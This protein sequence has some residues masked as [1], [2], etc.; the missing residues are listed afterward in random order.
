MT[1]PAGLKPT[2]I[3]EAARLIADLRLRRNGREGRIAGLPEHCRPR[4]LDD[5]YTIQER[6]RPLIAAGRLWT[7]RRLQ[8]RGDRAR[9]CR[10]GS[11]STIPVRARCS[12]IASTRAVPRS[13]G[14]LWR[15]LGVECEIGVRIGRDV[16]AR[17]GGHDRDSILPA[18]AA[19]FVSHR[20]RRA[21]FHGRP[22]RRR[23]DACRRRLLFS[24]RRC[25]DPSTHPRRSIP[26]ALRPAKS[27]STASKPSPDMSAT[28][29]AIRSTRSPGSP[30]IWRQRGTP[31]TAGDI[32]TLGSISPGT[33]IAS[34][35]W[36]RHGSRAWDVHGSGGLTAEVGHPVVA[37]FRLPYRP[38]GN[39]LSNRGRPRFGWQHLAPQFHHTG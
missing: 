31:L 13:R 24:R 30:T 21:S 27:S 23:R 2:A 17:A 14:T 22:H 12:A 3:D 1:Q 33:H 9:S 36:S 10:N 32:V 28:S 19:V 5:A 15:H 8:G 29:S 11:A 18:V 20:N 39:V 34:L 6:A 38:C 7:A 25:S 37:I 26:P 4:T 16:P 35:Q